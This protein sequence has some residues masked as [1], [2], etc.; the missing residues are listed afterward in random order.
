MGKSTA[1]TEFIG[2]P[3]TE[4]KFERPKIYSPVAHGPLRQA[5]PCMSHPT[6]VFCFLLNIFIPGL[7]TLISAFTVW[8]KE[9]SYE[10]QCTKHSVFFLNILTAF[11]QLLLTPLVVGYLWSLLWG[12]IFLQLSFKWYISNITDRTLGLDCW[13]CS[14]I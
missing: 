1:S 8:A 13:P 4:I 10:S 3:F 12:L 9:T 6:A 2:E 7:G 11:L 14:K 5:V